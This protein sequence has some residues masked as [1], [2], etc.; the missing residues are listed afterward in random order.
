M[1]FFCEHRPRTGE[2][3]N[4]VVG[5]WI[6]VLQYSSSWIGVLQYTGGKQGRRSVKLDQTH[7]DGAKNQLLEKIKIGDKMLNLGRKPPDT[8][9]SRSK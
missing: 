8:G 1:T 6:G 9:S 7:R 4:L 2:L 3:D 5:H